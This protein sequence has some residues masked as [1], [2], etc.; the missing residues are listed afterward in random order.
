VLAHVFKVVVD[1]FIGK[2]GVFKVH[3]GTFAR[4]PSCLSVTTNAFK[5]GAPVPLQGKDYVEVPALVPGDIGAV[6]K[7]EELEFD[8]VLHDSH[9]EDIFTS[10]RWH[11][12][13]PMQGLA[14]Q[15][16][17]KGDEQRLFEMSAQA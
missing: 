12:P 4:T 17:R 13:Q 14:V 1:P 9:D 16:K 5:V 15:T 3:Q 11:V 6:A 10:G 7:V 8:C 2:L